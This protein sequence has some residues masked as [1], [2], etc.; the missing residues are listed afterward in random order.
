MCDLNDFSMLIFSQDLTHEGLVIGG[1][2]RGFDAVQ[3]LHIGHKERLVG[4]Q[5]C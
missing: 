5:F 2:I 3:K 4:N 1:I